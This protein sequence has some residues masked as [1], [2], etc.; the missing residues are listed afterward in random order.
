MGTPETRQRLIDRLV[1]DAREVRPLWSP[2]ARLTLWLALGAALLGFYAFVGLRPDLASRV[3]HPLWVLEVALLF[4]AA[5]VFAAVSLVAAVP[6]GEPGVR[7]F[8]LAMVA[9]ALLWAFPFHLPAEA[10]V[11]MGQFLHLAYDCERRTCLLAV[12][13]A[14]ALMGALARGAPLAGARVGALA[15]AAAFLLAT[16][17]M[18]LICPSEERFHLLVGHVLP[19]VGGVALLGFLG[20]RLFRI[21]RLGG[22]GRLE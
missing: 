8:A 15:G 9:V 3:R 12:L 19:A 21:G 13:P 6:A 7:R 17:I 4:A 5:A 10:G 2:A 14:V 11:P 16:G 22:A 20:S 18:R 1:A